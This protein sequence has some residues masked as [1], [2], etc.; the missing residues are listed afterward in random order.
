MGSSAR[1]RTVVVGACI[2]CVM[3]LQPAAAITSDEIG[4]VRAWFT[5][6]SIL[7]TLTAPDTGLGPARLE[8]EVPRGTL[9]DEQAHTFVEEVPQGS[10]EV[11][12]DGSFAFVNH[13]VR[14][15]QRV[16]ASWRP[17]GTTVSIEQSEGNTYL[18]RFADCVRD[19]GYIGHAR[20]GRSI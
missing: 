3:S 7:T 12:P 11:S 10:Y 4:I 15:W 1:M 5:E 9:P 8:V 20:V 16:V 2:A 14:G 6:G 18:M 13:D 19:W 17:R